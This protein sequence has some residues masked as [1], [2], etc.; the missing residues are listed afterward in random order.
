[1]GIPIMISNIL[2]FIRI[3]E[4]PMVFM[5]L[6]FFLSRRPISIKKPAPR[7]NMQ[8]SIHFLAFVG[9][10]LMPATVLAADSDHLIA[11]NHLNAWELV[12]MDIA[13]A[14][15]SHITV[16]APFMQIELQHGKHSRSVK[17]DGTNRNLTHRRVLRQPTSWRSFRADFLV[18]CR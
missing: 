17:L 1:M 11:E 3:R 2:L 18:Q 9:P 12:V 5:A 16:D 6:V 10:L 13:T 7:L 15:G 8:C 14:N 4:T